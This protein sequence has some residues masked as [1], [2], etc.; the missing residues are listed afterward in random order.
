MGERRKEG[1]RERKERE[2]GEREK[3]ETAGEKEIK[4]IM[5]SRS[6]LVTVTGGSPGAVRFCEESESV[7]AQSCSTLRPHGL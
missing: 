2:K 4:A 1:R 7:A 5:V 3:G 6:S